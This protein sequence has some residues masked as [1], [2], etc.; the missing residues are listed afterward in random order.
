MARTLFHAYPRP[1]CQ[2]L[3]S[4]SSGDMQLNTV[5]PGPFCFL[6][7]PRP[8]LRPRLSLVLAHL[9]STL[10]VECVRPPVGFASHL[11]VA[12]TALMVMKV[13]VT[14]LLVTTDQHFQRESS[15]TTD[16]VRDAWHTT[17]RH[18]IQSNSVDHG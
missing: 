13:A 14:T 5:P 16:W 11:C 3:A 1:A 2:E 10:L 9:I 6:L 15:P 7:G 18:D 17:P 12:H 4:L 8:S